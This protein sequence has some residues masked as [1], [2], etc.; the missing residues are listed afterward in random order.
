MFVFLTGGRR[1]VI[2]PEEKKRKGSSLLA[3]MFGA[4]EHTIDQTLHEVLVIDGLQMRMSR[5][6]KGKHREEKCATI[7]QSNEKR[8]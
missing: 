1:H 4:F 7:S 8:L 2:E 5:R 6:E 3:Q